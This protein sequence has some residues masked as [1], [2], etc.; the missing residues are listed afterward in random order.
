MSTGFLL[1]SI[2]IF[3]AKG[4]NILLRAEINHER[5]LIRTADANRIDGSHSLNGAET[6]LTW[7]R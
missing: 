3:S 1:I 2:L 5:W 6:K 7:P 4:K